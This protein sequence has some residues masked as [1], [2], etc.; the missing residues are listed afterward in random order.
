MMRNVQAPERD[1]GAE[2]PALEAGRYRSVSAAVYTNDFFQDYN[3]PG[4]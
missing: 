1:L 4:F 3:T 2:H